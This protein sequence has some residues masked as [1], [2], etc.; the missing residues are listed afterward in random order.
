MA[1]LGIAELEM[2]V[3]VAR[4]RS[5][6]GAAA[7]QG[8]SAAALSE[9]VR[10]LEKRLGVQLL[11]RTTRSVTITEAGLV[12]L[13][14][15][16]PALEQIGDALDAVNGHRATPRGTLRLNVPTIVAD[17][18]LPPMIQRFLKR[19]PEVVLDV[20]AED[21][22]I[23]IFKEGFDAGVRYDERLEQDVIAIPIGPRIQRLPS[24]R[25]PPIG[26]REASRSTQATCSITPASGTTL[27]IALLPLGNLS[28]ARKRLRWTRLPYCPRTRWNCVSARRWPESG[29][30]PTLKSTFGPILRQMRSSLFYRIVALV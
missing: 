4:H 13:A 19:C 20:A 26:L 24:P 3:T 7:A 30:S 22:V 11:N 5:F 16:E 23:D 6:R 9:A 2:F 10:R 14:K 8:V 29:Q 18:I 21:R 28:A 15:L 27:S 12:L 1:G 25:P 17:V